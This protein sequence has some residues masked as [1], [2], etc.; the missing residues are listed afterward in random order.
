MGEL[1]PIVVNGKREMNV[2]N[3]H[4]IIMA[5]FTRLL[6][7]IFCVTLLFIP[8]ALRVG[9]IY[10]IQEETMNKLYVMWCFCVF[11]CSDKLQLLKEAV[12]L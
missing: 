12:F 7:M 3:I 10:L 2:G 8:N 9:N 1:L 5:I 6:G 11:Y 4:G